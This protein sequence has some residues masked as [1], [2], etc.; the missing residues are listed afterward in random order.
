MTSRQC[1]KEVCLSSQKEKYTDCI[2]GGRNKKELSKLSQIVQNRIYHVQNPS[3]CQTARKMV[4]SLWHSGYTAQ[5][6]RLMLV[7]M[8]AYA[9]N[10]TLIIVDKDWWFSRH[11][12]NNWEDFHAPLSETCKDP[13]G[14]STEKWNTKD[15][16]RHVQVLECWDCVMQLNPKRDSER[17]TFRYCICSRKIPSK[18]TSLVGKSICI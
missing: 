4:T 12:A 2:H 7:F 16:Q 17:D 15:D 8:Y 13:S 14:N 6:H 11:A 10:R 5:I 9:S 3:N 1:L 18:T